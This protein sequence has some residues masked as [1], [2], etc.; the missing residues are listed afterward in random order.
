MP[1][2]L[3][4]LRVPTL[5]LEGWFKQGTRECVVLENL[6]PRDARIVDVRMD[7]L[8]SG[9]V[10][11]TLESARFDPIEDGQPIPE[12]PSPTFTML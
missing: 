4:I 5:F 6:L 8:R 2:R 1:R 12:A 7:P 9:T 11:F 3:R 10:A